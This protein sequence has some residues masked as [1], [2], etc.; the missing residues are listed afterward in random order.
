MN[1][2][3][4]KHWECSQEFERS[5]LSPTYSTPFWCGMPRSPMESKLI[6]AESESVH[7]DWLVPIWQGHL[8]NWAQTPCGV[9]AFYS[10]STRTGLGL[11]RARTRAESEDWNWSAQTLLSDWVHKNWTQPG[12]NPQSPDYHV[13]LSAQLTTLPNGLPSEL[14]YLGNNHLLPT[15]YRG[16]VFAAYRMWPKIKVLYI[17]RCSF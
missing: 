7:V 12:L 17:T 5:L 2:R 6:C 14:C 13:M 8:C 10:D 9:W 4:H 16:G 3:L 11:V 1:S 15:I